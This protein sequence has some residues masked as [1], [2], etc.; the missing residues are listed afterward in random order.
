MVEQ[1]GTFAI[2]VGA[3]ESTGSTTYIS[4]SDD[5]I[6]LVQ[7]DRTSIATGDRVSLAIPDIH[8]HAFDPQTGLRI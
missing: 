1:Q 2:T 5:L 3:I 8:V 6:T 7:A 4:S